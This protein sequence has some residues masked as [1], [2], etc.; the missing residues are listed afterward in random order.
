[1]GKQTMKTKAG[2]WMLS[3]WGKRCSDFDKNCALCK[4]WKAYDY[5][6]AFEG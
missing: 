4:A 2:R 1:M 5:L 3:M 6:F